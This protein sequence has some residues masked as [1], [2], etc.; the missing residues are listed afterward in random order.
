[1]LTADQLA[2]G[3]NA[4]LEEIKSSPLTI[5]FLEMGFL[6]GKQLMVIKKAPFKGPIAFLIDGNIVALR[7]QEASLLE[8]SPL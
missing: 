7:T 3:Q 5:N 1:M 6:P 8:V 2:I 4:R